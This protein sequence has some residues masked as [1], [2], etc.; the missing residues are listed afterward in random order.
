MADDD[1]V[2]HEED[3]LPG[4]RRTIRGVL[5]VAVAAL[6]IAVVSSQ[7]WLAYAA[8]L[9]I[10]IGGISM[11]SLRR[12]SSLQVTPDE[13][14][15]G[16]DRLALADLDP[17]FGVRRGEDELTDGVRASLEV[18]LSS[19]RGDLNILGGSFGRPK[20][21][22]AWLVVQERNG[23]QHVIA[24]RDAQALTTAIRSRLGPTAA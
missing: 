6:L 3:A 22:S 1:T 14:R 13:L 11:W 4:G 20:T 17:N 7:F 23:Q 2:I 8:G 24:S 19:R 21:G 15:V 9:V 16:R 18:G 10:V 12:Y 5:G